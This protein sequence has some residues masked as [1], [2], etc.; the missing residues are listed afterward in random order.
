MARP[1]KGEEK[2]R[3]HQVGFRATDAVRQAIDEVAEREGKSLSDVLNEV[4]E[5]QLIRRRK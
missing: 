5:K 4:V 2:N 1:K 3:P